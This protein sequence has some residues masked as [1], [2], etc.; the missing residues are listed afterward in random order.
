MHQRMAA[1][2]KTPLV[3]RRSQLQVGRSPRGADLVGKAVPHVNDLALIHAFKGK[4]LR[5]EFIDLANSSR[6]G[7][8]GHEDNLHLSSPGQPCDPV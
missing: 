8:E 3:P 4:H 2:G 7:F 6:N 5:N 1:E